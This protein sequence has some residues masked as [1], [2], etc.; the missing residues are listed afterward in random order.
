VYPSIARAA[1]VKGIVILEAVIDAHG[2]V[3]SVQVLRSNPLLD[4]AAVDAVR[5]W[6]YMP[7]RLN[8]QPI[9]VVVTVTIN[10]SMQ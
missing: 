1:H 10:F 8:G 5:Q 7:A 4:Q 6:R 9:A 3:T 2:N